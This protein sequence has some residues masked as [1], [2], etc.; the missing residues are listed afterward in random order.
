MIPFFG[1]E[2]I[3]V[4]GL[5][6]VRVWGTLVALGYG[7][8]TWVAYRR[9]KTKGLNGDHVLTIAAWMFFAA[10][11]GARFFHVFVYEPGYYFAHPL[12]AIDLRLPGYAIT[13]GFLGAASVF[14]VY[15]KR[16]KLDWMAYA[17]T[18]AW[19][20]PWGCGVGRIGCFLIHDHPGTLTHFVLGVKYP[21]GVVRHDLGLYLS[22]VGFVAGILF[23]LLDRKPRPPGFWAAM[24][25]LIDGASRFF[26]DF[27]RIV[28][29]RYIG[30]TPAQW[31][32]ALFV[33]IGL[34]WLGWMYQKKVL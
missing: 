32:G 17:D 25:L 6:S 2:T 33:V 23:L 4:F 22:I 10:M 12:E 29:T 16:Y 14:F 34:S 3:S 8:G 27:L 21:N 19:G 9:A 1:A 11:I 24:F 20:L 28:D 15:A 31:A 7:L 26:L 30:L 13:G 18:L 5:F